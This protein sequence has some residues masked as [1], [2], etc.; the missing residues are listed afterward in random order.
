MSNLSVF[1]FESNEVRTLGTALEPL[2][3]GLDICKILEISNSRD[4]LERLDEDEKLMSL[5]TTSGQGREMT[6]I[7]ESGLWSLV[8]TSRKP[9]AKRF[10][11]WLT[12]E[13]I[14]A[15]RKTG[16]Y[17]TKPA[18]SLALIDTSKLDAL[19]AKASKLQEEVRTLETRLASIR[20][21][22]QNIR[23]EEVAI[24]KALIT[25]HPDV[26]KHA[27]KC[28]EILEAY[29]DGNKYFSNPLKK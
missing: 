7:N 25:S 29:G 6:V 2:F 24:A 3:V 1:N 23:M 16:T 15:I 27:I 18:T 19:N 13:V 20:N 17:S 9:Q 11:K 28:N 5:I 14:P 8:L 21:E 26:V 12:S 4:A 22:L 10:K